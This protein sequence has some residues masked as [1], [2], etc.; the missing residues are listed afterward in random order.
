MIVTLVPLIKLRVKCVTTIL[1]KRQV[2]RQV[3]VHSCGLDLAAGQAERSAKEKRRIIMNL[4]ISLFFILAALTTFWSQGPAAAFHSG[5]VAEC[6]SC[7]TMHNSMSGVSMSDPASD[8]GTARGNPLLSGSDSSSVC[9]KCHAAQDTL[10][11]GGNANSPHI[12]SLNQPIPV[13]RT[14][15][16]DFA[17]LK[18]SWSWFPIPTDPTS[19]KNS[20]GERHGHN[21]VAADFGYFADTSTAGNVA[22][23]GIYPTDQLHC[24]SCHDPHGK[25]RQLP[26][27]IFDTSGGPITISGSYG[28]EPSVIGN[29][30]YAVG[31]YR[32]LGGVN[33]KPSSLTGIPAFIEPPMFATVETTYNRSEDTNDVVVAYGRGSSEW[34]RNCHNT[35]HDIV[36]NG[37]FSHS[38]S[39]PLGDTMANIYNSYVK[40]GDLTGIGGG[41]TSLVPVQRGNIAS[42]S[43]LYNLLSTSTVQFNDQVTCLTCHRAHA[44]GWDKILRFPYGTDFMTIMDVSGNPAYPDPIANPAEAMGRT[45]AEFQAALYDRPASKFGVFQKALC[46]KCHSQ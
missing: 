43:S 29:T 31:A 13:E 23:G 42:N 19:R 5:G 22:P 39:I 32:L 46:E 8:I 16:G 7:H 2:R 28:A 38:V 9:L 15:G 40:T 35:I 37:S 27:G 14:P 44:S 33:Y 30:V 25:Y 17:W 10:P 4:R 6:E 26:G 21:I 12:M 1:R 45:P 24:I 18:K 41:F 11:G 34:C 20:P 3:G 36:S